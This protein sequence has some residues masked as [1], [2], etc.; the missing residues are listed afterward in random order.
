ML[1]MGLEHTS[2]W[3][4]QDLQQQAKAT[5]FTPPLIR[6]LPSVEPP[7]VLQDDGSISLNISIGI[8]MYIYQARPSNIR[9]IFIHTFNFPAV[10]PDP[11]VHS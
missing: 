4:S 8:R 3:C 7:F 10:C 11:S 5:N 2:D 9:R 1:E 6:R